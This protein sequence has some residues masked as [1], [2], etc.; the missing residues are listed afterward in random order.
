MVPALTGATIGDWPVVDARKGVAQATPAL[1]VAHGVP[2][3][4]E[5]VAFYAARHRTLLAIV[6]ATGASEA[7][8]E[9]AV[10]ATMYEV[11]LRWSQITDPFAWARR[12]VVTH[13][14][15]DRTRGPERARRRLAVRGAGT[16]TVAED[17]NLTMA[18]GAEWVRQLLAIL[19][20]GQYDVMTLAVDGYT[21]AEIAERLGR[22]PEA[23][24]RARSDARQRLRQA[25]EHD[26]EWSAGRAVRT[27]RTE[28]R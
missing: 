2:A 21:T 18:E 12:A 19:P 25:L 8:A 15:K 28:A 14:I 11:M 20:P 23:V 9:D 22:S 27:P 3:R 17:P 7:E 5:F 4:R 6:V 26:D 16:P 24:R 13:F 1:R 10:A